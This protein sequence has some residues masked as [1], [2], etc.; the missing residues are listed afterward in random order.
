MYDLEKFL[1]LRY[2]IIYYAY[3]CKSSD[4]NTNNNINN[5][6]N[7]DNSIANLYATYTYIGDKFK[8]MF[9]AYKLLDDRYVCVC[10]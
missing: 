5:N 9:M 7:S 6:D 2:C 10:V 8:R 3:L 4:N 1:F